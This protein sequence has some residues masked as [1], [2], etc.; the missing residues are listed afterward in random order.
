ME[1]CITE[2]VSKSL[3]AAKKEVEEL[4]EVLK[5]NVAERRAIAQALY[6]VVSLGEAAL[7]R[8][9][10]GMI[11]EDVLPTEDVTVIALRKRL[12]AVEAERDSALEDAATLC[13][14]MADTTWP[15]ETGDMLRDAAR[16]IRA[17]KKKA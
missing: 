10:V 13:E 15:R 7:G 8:H 2:E 12:V 6:D 5:V 3:A 14:K 4:R 16:L 1:V 17:R 11:S 9:R